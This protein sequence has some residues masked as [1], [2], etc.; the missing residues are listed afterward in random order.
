[1]KCEWCDKDIDGSFGSGRFCDRSC[2]TRFSS[3]V[4]RKEK[5]R[6][7]AS[8]LRVHP[9]FVKCRKCEVLFVPGKTGGAVHCETHMQY[10]RNNKNPSFDRIKTDA[11]RREY[12]KR[13]RGHK[14]EVCK[15]KSWMKK[16]IPL[17]LDHIDGDCRNNIKENLRLI[18]PNC[19]AQTDTYKGKNVG[20]VK[21]SKRQQTQKKHPI[22]KYR[23]K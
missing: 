14:C 20:R 18:C 1:M 19:H 17:E 7:I 9:E 23:N 3:N 16:K 2:S 5:N 22:A 6:K 8:T 10:N 11:S 15:R 4:N 21:D 12:L 13:E